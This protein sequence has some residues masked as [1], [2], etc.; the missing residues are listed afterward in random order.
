MSSGLVSPG[1][2]P[3]TA[4]SKPEAKA[5]S[6]DVQRF[7]ASMADGVL[8]IEAES[9]RLQEGNVLR[10]LKAASVAECVMERILTAEQTKRMAVQLA[11][12]LFAKVRIVSAHPAPSKCYVKTHEVRDAFDAM[13]RNGYNGIPIM[14]LAPTA[15]LQAVGKDMQAHARQGPVTPSVAKAVEKGPTH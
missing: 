10:K 3:L 15:I 8:M 13:I 1:G 5:P 2:A 7:L 6:P 4:A 11:P 9:F 14:G 12:H